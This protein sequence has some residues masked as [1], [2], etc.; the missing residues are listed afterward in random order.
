VPLF[1]QAACSF[2]VPPLVATTVPFCINASAS[3]NMPVSAVSV[4]PVLLIT[5]A[6]IVPKPSMFA[7][8]VIVEPISV[9]PAILRRPL[10]CHACKTFSVP[11]LVTTNVPAWLGA[12]A[13]VKV[14]P[15]AVNVAPP[16]FCNCGVMVPKPVIV[17]AFTIVEPMAVP[18]NRLS[19][20]LFCQACSTLSVAA[21]LMAT[22]PSWLGAIASV[23]APPLAMSVPPPLL[24]TCGVIVPKPVIVPAF[25]MVEPTRLPPCRLTRPLFNH[26]CSTFNVPALPIF[27]QPF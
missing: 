2:K 8:F 11:V 12:S 10:F 7:A 3:V 14:P 4:A 16:L 23:N 18:P 17:D 19:V 13:S 9:P 27:T 1:C 6:V 26:A 20:P 22:L 5:G 25:V 21:L 24:R 15:V